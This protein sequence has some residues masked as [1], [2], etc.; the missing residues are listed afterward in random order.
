L[1]ELRENKAFTIKNVLHT[2]AEDKAIS[3]PVYHADRRGK[4]ASRSQINNSAE[5]ALEGKKYFDL[6]ICHDHLLTKP[7]ICAEFER[8]R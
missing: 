4:S 2:M 1:A 8:D 5:N 3:E 7:N 6:I